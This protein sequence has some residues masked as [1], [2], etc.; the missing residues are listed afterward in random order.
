MSEPAGR[1]G[2]LSREERARL[3][4]KIRQKKAAMLPAAGGEPAPVPVPR[5]PSG[6]PLSSSQERMW[7]LDRLTPG[8]AI[9]NLP[10]VVRLLGGLD[11]AVLARCFAEVCRRHEV[12]RTTF[13]LRGNEPVQVIHP[14]GPF[15]LPVADLACLTAEARRREAHR[16]VD[17]GK[18]APFD[19]ERGPLLR[20]FLLRLAP[21]EHVLLI[22]QHHIVT[23]G[24]SKNLL[25]RE[26][27][28]LYE[29]FAAGRPSPLPELPVQYADVAVWQRERLR[30]PAAQ[31]QL[32][33]WRERLAGPLEVLD[34][35]LDHVRPAVQ[36]F[37]GDVL[38]TLLPVDCADR[39]RAFARSE[40][41]S[42]F[43]V[44]LAGLG[45]LLHRWSGQ[46]DVLIGTPIAGRV[47]PELE[48]L[49]GLFLNT[50]VLRVDLSGQPARRELLARARETALGAYARQEVPFEK[51]LEELRPERDLSRTPLFQVFLN[52]LNFPE[53]NAR[54]P[55]GLLF[56]LIEDEQFDSK[57]DLTLYAQEVPD[58]LDLVLVY[59]ADLFERARME[60]MQRQLRGVL[61][62]LAAAPDAPIDTVS[63]LTAEAAALLPDPTAPL[64]KDR[65][66]NGRIRG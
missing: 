18:T 37:R 57:F 9:Y 4:E 28:V 2:Q 55:G 41:A 13:A 48:S 45:L 20:T 42:L 54:L 5:D 32:A 12:L 66:P 52:L 7:L 36:T 38:R 59:N 46:E 14:P 15:T 11:S 17:W 60:E 8:T 6:M 16:L 40:K 56:E 21:E 33:W 65:A 49:I 35:P 25:L 61:E 23:D 53:I 51:L 63:L 44:L 3:F 31:G 62:Q 64:E 27:T 34:L 1:L 26:L 22:V 19:L 29:A 39:L 10:G 58:G 50:L 24:W 43:M 47:R 30:G